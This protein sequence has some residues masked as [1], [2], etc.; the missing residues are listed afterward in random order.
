MIAFILPPKMTAPFEKCKKQTTLANV[1]KKTGATQTLIG[2]FEYHKAKKYSAKME[3]VFST[4]YNKLLEQ[5]L[6]K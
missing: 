3:I 5:A 4:N 1:K 2:C 6:A